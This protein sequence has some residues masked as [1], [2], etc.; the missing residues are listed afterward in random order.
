MTPKIASPGRG[1]GFYGWFALAGGT[2]VIFTMGGS[3][4]HAFGVMLPVI[5]GEFGW[6][7]AT[8]ALALSMGIMA[9]GLPSP[10]FGMLV[11]RFG[12]RFTVIWGNLLG[13]LGL[14]GMALV[15]ETWH[16]YIIYIIM[17]A[18]AGFGGYIAIS[19]VVVNWFV[20]KRSLALGIFMACG[21]MGGFVFPPMVTALIS[22]IGWRMTWL[23]LGGI[24]AVLGVLVGG[25]FLTRNKPE[26]MGQVPDGTT[27]GVFD[28]AERAEPEPAAG[29]GGGGKIRQIMRERTVWLIGAFAGANAF[30]LGTM[31]THQIAYLQDIGFN[32]MTA[33]TTVSLLSAMVVIGSITLG[34]LALR[35][36]VG[37]LA[38]IGFAFELMAIIVLLTTKELGLIYIYA[39]LLGI[40]SGAIVT[41]M[42]TFVG[43]YYQ[44]ERY[45][46]ALG[47]V[48]PF[49]VVFQAVGATTAGAIYDAADSYKLAFVAVAVCLVLGMFFV[50]AA[51]PRRQLQASG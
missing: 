10:L 37:Y 30:A 5:C 41:A 11:T 43:V 51:R 20:K 15:Q 50:F 45:A 2:L 7:R 8:V 26:D 17:G 49:Q 29:E 21:G 24:V 35:M 16:V 18:G 42:P 1:G 40:G 12:P 44:R 38:I 14:A 9:F 47:I 34:A 39:V 28:E 25:V 13:A 36:N 19:Q 48:L 23:A 4:V 27:A 32:A 33:A 46:Q 3:F 22:T 6:S 31:N